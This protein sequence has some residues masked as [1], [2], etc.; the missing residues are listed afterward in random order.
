MTHTYSSVQCRSSIFSNC[1]SSTGSLLKSCRSTVFHEVGLFDDF[2][3]RSARC[4]AEDFDRPLRADIVPGRT[5][6]TCFEYGESDL[7]V[8]ASDF[9]STL[10]GGVAGRA[11]V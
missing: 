3:R 4:R 7:L 10:S 6:T 5:L 1:V 8:D 9:S 2:L 11:L